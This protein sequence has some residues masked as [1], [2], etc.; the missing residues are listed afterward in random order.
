MISFAAPGG[1]V[2]PHVDQYDVFLL[3]AQGRRRWEVAQAFDPALVPDAPLKMLVTFQAEQSWE[4]E[5]GDLLYLPPGVAHHGV[6]LDPGLTYSIGLRAPSAADLMLGFGEWLAEHADEG[7][8]YADP[9]LSA[10]PRAGELDTAAVHH[11][12][13]LLQAA[14]ERDGD[15][16]DFL[17]AWLSRYRLAHDPAPPP[18]AIEATTLERALLRGERLFHHPWTRLVWSGD[19]REACLYAAGQRFECRAG[20]AEALCANPALDT[21]TLSLE[22]A[23]IHVLTGLLNAG[24]LLLE[25]AGDAP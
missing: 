20:L 14:L 10:P 25:P 5:P 12:R 17:T 7:G 4:L 3:Q 9:D 6:A 23:D 16:R 18:E 15:W 22:G 1:G 13:G 8:R 11:A 2:G 19:G 21:G 24:H